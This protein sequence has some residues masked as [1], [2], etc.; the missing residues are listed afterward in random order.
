[1][2]WG[3]SSRGSHSGP[4]RDA[5]VV[6]RPYYP[7]ADEEGLAEYYAMIADASSLVYLSTAETG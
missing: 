2:L 1:M 6:L 5:L 3:L 4:A 7:N